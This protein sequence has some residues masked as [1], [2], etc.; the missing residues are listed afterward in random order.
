M[1]ILALLQCL[2]SAVPR[3]TLRQCSRIV[4]ALLVMTGRVT[5]L[6]ISRWAG[7]GGSY[8]TV[9]RFFS[10]ALPWAM[11]FWVFFRQHVYRA[12]EVYLL[13]GDEVVATKA[14][15]HTHGLDRFFSSL[16]GKPVPGLAF[17]ALSL[18]STQQRRSFPIRVEQVV[19]SDA[20]KAA[21]KAKAEAKKQTL[22][23][24]KRRPGRPK[25]S[26]NTPKADV[27]LTPEFLR[28]T[29]MLGALL[30]LIAGAVSLTYLVLDGHFGNHNALQMARQNHLHLI[31]KLR[32]DA[33]LYFPYTGPYAGRGPHRKYGGKVDYDNIPTQYLKETTVEGHIET[34]LYQAH[35]LHKEFAQPLHVVI[36]T[37]THLQTQARGHVV[38]FSSDLE[39]A[40]ASLV[41][42]YGLRFQ[43]EFNF[44]DAK[45]YWGLEDFMN[46][47]PT[48]VTNAANLSL[49]MVNV[50]YRLQADR[51]Q[52]DPAYSVLD[53]KAD[54]RGSKYVEETIKMLPEKPEPVLLEQIRNKVACLGRIHAAQPFCSFS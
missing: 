9:Q 40:Y 45:Q 51:R 31:S 17:F 35:M 2:Q 4:A 43:I 10:Q 22:S 46:I 41:D 25:G 7:P 5:M 13:V 16:Y 11:L 38:L 33:A 39:L 49:F 18:V 34:R 3:T 15:T 20:E 53:V 37:K 32:Y 24:A 26:K 54:C 27:T 6:G 21:S 14:G 36:I 42:Y 19:R 29:G 1:D 52:R 12:D 47:T 50:S 30:P 44:R 28:I 8:R 23:T 48:G